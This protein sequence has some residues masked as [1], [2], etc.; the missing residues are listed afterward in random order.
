MLPHQWKLAIIDIKDCFFTVPLHPRDAPQFAFSVPSLNKQ[1]PMRRYHWH[2]LSQG[3]KYLPTIC[4][5]YMAHVLSPVRKEF[6]RSIILH[7]MDDILICAPDN[8]YLDLTLKE[9]IRAIEKAGFEIQT[10]KI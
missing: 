3:M 10:E 8:S 1:A 5:W 9:T 6:A 2:I 4:Q 7:Y